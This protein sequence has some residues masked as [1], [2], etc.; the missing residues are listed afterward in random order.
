VSESGISSTPHHGPLFLNGRNTR[1]TGS[2]SF[3]FE[4]PGIQDVSLLRREL[5]EKNRRY[6]NKL[7]KKIISS[8]K[9]IVFFFQ[10]LR[11][12]NGYLTAAK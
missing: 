7:N 2:R 6:K 9:L 8:K 10:S 3:D 5:A 11:A 4:S 12:G 1:G